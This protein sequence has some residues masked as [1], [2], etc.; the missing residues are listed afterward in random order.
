M[1][2]AVASFDV[3]S[4]DVDLPLQPSVITGLLA[5]KSI[6]KKPPLAGVIAFPKEM[7]AELTVPVST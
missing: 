1:Q 7:A 2:H 3:D 5:T 4:D 6:L